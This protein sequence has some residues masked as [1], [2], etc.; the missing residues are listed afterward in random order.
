MSSPNGKD[1]SGPART[2]Y[3]L[4]HDKP[5]TKIRKLKNMQKRMAA[6]DLTITQRVA[7]LGARSDVAVLR[8]KPEDLTRNRAF[9]Q[10]Q[11]RLRSAIARLPQDVFKPL[12]HRIA[13]M[14]YRAA[15][16]AMEENR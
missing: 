5:T 4:H 11:Q 8:M 2:R 9:V 14:A 1:N 13:A 7:D 6:E 10:H 12:P 16:I 3:W 15:F